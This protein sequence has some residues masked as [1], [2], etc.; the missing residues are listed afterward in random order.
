MELN[1]ILVGK[2]KD[3]KTVEIIDLV[4]LYF[5]N[6]QLFNKFF[7]ESQMIYNYSFQKKRT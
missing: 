5:S 1:P 6:R 7:R 2:T 4:Q 3:N